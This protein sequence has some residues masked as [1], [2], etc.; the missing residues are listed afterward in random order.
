MQLVYHCDLGCAIYLAV[1]TL[2]LFFFVPV[3]VRAYIARVLCVAAQQN[4]RPQRVLYVTLFV[5]HTASNVRLLFA[6]L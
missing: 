6:L 4:G 1:C 5:T 2:T 3:E